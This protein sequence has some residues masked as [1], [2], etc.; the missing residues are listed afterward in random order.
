[1]ADA[2][3]EQAADGKAVAL[4]QGDGEEGRDG[5]EGDGGADVDEAE[6]DADDGG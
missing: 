4:E 2:A 6:A 5:V 1:M 3:P